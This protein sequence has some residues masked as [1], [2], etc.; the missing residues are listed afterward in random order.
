MPEQELEQL[1]VELTQEVRERHFGKYRGTVESVDDTDQLGRVTAKVPSVYGDVTSPW[2]LPAFPFAG[3][4]YGVI[5]LPKQGDGVWIEF[6]GGNPARPIWTGF[7][8]ARNELVT[9]AEREK[10]VLVTP[11]GLEVVLDDASKELKL[12][13]PDGP[14][15]TIAAGEIT[16]DAGATIKITDSEIKV[17]AGGGTIKVSSSGV[18]IN[19]G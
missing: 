18:A 19:D 4:G 11:E 1:M 10:R 16:L 2:A 14:T 7:W 9:G 5:F 12:I 13:H 17:E 15:L 8:C 3:P 6:E